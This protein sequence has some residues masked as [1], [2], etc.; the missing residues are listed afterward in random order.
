MA[1]TRMAPL[2]L[3]LG[4]DGLTCWIWYLWSSMAFTSIVHTLTSFFLLMLGSPELPPD[5]EQRGTRNKGLGH[6]EARQ[7]EDCQHGVRAGGVTPTTP[8]SW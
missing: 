5:T 2:A 4:T 8:A 3:P 6:E 7:N 1:T